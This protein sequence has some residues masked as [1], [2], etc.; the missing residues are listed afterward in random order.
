MKLKNAVATAL[1][2]VIENLNNTINSSCVLLDLS[3]ALHSIK[4][5]V[6]LDKVYKHG[7]CGILHNLVKIDLTNITQQVQITHKG[8]EI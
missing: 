3:K 2:S 5:K 6:H 8:D 4:Y 1:S 7:I